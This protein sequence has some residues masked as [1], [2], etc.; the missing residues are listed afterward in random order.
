LCISLCVIIL[1]RTKPSQGPQSGQIERFLN[2]GI[3]EITGQN[4]T[5]GHDGFSNMLTAQPNTP[6]GRNH[7]NH[8]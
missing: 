6:S 4:F 1:N 5:R 3:P 7:G 8:I 2:K